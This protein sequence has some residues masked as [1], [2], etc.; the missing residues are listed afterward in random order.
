MGT[1][2]L[3]ATPIGNLEDITLRALQVLKEVSLI[4]A[5]DTRTTRKLL[6]RYA[7]STP[8]VS[9]HEHSPP[10]RL[11]E[12]LEALAQGDV[13]VVSEAGM[14]GISDPGYRLV[15]E[16]IAAGFP[17]VP[18][19]GPSAVTTALAASGLPADRFLFLGF[20]PAR[21]SARR[22]VLAEISSLPYTLICFEAPHRI[23]ETLVDALEIL[24]DRRLAMARELTKAHE[25]IWRGTLGQ[26]L[27]HFRAQPPRG[28]FT[29][30]IA[31]AGEAGRWD[32]E[33]VRRELARLLG[34]GFSLKEAAR[35]VAG[36]AGWSRREVYQLGLRT[37]A[38][39]RPSAKA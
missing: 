11:A 2:Y 34:E 10:A 36:Q 4:A 31:G 9:F 29:L 19:P 32:E 14:P 18:I 17:I 13:A 15:Q 38:G 1:L 23:I 25:E 39:T 24:G 22:K 6:A 30:V 27:E 7:I 33:Q 21:A 35:R 16:A 12:L 3:V 8:M 37:E 28:E 26:A 20:L 5:E